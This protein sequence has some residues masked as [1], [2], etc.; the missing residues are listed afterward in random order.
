MTLVFKKNKMSPSS[1]LG[2]PLGVHAHL[3]GVLLA[4][5]E[6]STQHVLQDDGLLA[7]GD[8]ILV[9]VGVTGLGVNEGQL[10]LLKSEGWRE[11]WGGSRKQSSEG[12][13]WP[14]GSHWLARTWMD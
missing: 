4:T 1:A 14:T 11:R 2:P 13:V 12:T 9:V 5:L 3:A 10:Q 6:A 7:G 8:G